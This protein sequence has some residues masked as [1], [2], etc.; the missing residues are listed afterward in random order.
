MILL[1]VWPY[2]NMHTYTRH[3]YKVAQSN[4]TTNVLIVYGE[5]ILPEQ[6]VTFLAIHVASLLMEKFTST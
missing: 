6:M 4:S 2:F 3:I 1:C 5:V